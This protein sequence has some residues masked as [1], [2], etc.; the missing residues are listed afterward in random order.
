MASDTIRKIE[1][2][3]RKATGKTV[4]ELEE[5]KERKPQQMFLPGLEE[6][7]RAIPNHIARS[8]LF[9]PVARG[10]KKYHD[11]TPLVTRADAVI[12]YSGIQL[13]ES[14]ADV[15]M[16][17]VYLARN[18]PLGEP[19]E[20]NRSA[21]LKGIGRK[22]GGYQYKWL[23]QTLKAF[24]KATIIVEAKRKD[25]S[26]KYH[27]GHTRTL[28]MMEFDYNEEDEVY[29]FTIDP[30]WKV[31]FSN[32]EYSLLDWEKRLQINQGQDMAKALQRHFATSNSNPQRHAMDSL[33]CAMQYTGRMS[34]FKRVAITKA[35]DEL[36]RL[37]IVETWRFEQS[38]KNKEQLVV[39]LVEKMSA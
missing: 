34:E 1:E 19:V 18:T 3:A 2:L 30:R 28:R 9:A 23:H 29:T 4:D 20:I 27:I 6:A 25:G 13:D 31:L 7:F 37:A 38:T 24:A 17:L 22:T 35:L 5:Q 21:L 12:T 16:H 39:F 36:T 32:R 14:Q 8:S 15:W 26:M 33:R 11:E 10:R